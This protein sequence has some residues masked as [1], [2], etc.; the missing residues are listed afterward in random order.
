ML[1]LT[2]GM[3]IFLTVHLIPTFVDLRRKLIGW[4]GD[5]FYKIGYSCAALTGL[6]LIIIGKGRAAYVPVWEPPGWAFQITQITMLIVLILLPAA[7]L[8]T[9]LKRFMRH[10]FLTGLAL[11]A[12]S[13]LLVNGDLASIVLFGGFGVFALFDIWSANR[14][15]A[16]KTDEKFPVYRDMILVVIGIIVYGA[17]LYL[18]PY[19]FGV[20]AVP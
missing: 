13:H 4:E 5:A 17:I 12:L 18:H 15:G 1:L 8:P 10:P 7:Y 9:N 16:K 20:S 6:I 2:L 11:W 14:R 3:V 19:L